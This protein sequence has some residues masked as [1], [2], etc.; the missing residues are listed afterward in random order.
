MNSAAVLIA[1]IATGEEAETKRTNEMRAKAGKAGGKA[2]AIALTPEERKA[3]A[4][5]A[6]EAKHRKT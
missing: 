1:R 6:A 4:E 2:R 3:I 5:K